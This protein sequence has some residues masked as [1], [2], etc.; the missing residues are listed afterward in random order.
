MTP[1]RKTVSNNLRFIVDRYFHE[2]PKLMSRYLDVP[3]A[4][5]YGWCKGSFSVTENWMPILQE[6][7][8]IRPWMLFFPQLKKK[9]DNLVPQPPIDLE[10]V[11]SLRLAIGRRPGD[12][13]K[14]KEKSK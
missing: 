5:V 7:L 1:I 14:R 6:E 8:G 10:K 2:N 3:Y 9:W 12:G 11:E 13:R 4:T